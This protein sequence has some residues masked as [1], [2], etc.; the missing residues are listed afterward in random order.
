MLGASISQEDLK[1]PGT[2]D[3]TSQ[4][5]E[6]ESES[7]CVRENRVRENRGSWSIDQANPRR[8][9]RWRA[10]HCSRKILASFAPLGPALSGSFFCAL[11]IPINELVCVP[12]PRKLRKLRI[13]YTCH[14]WACLRSSPRDMLTHHDLSLIRRGS[15]ALA[16]H[17]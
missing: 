7:R 15:S 6:S 14:A 12:C 4:S 16:W 9:T 17:A 5:H 8:K 13:A 10:K 2:P 3:A 11:R 1:L